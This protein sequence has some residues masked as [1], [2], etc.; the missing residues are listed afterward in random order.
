MNRALN[1]LSPQVLQTRLNF[2][3]GHKWFFKREFVISKVCGPTPNKYNFIVEQRNVF[4]QLVEA[5]PSLAK[6]FLWKKRCL[7]PLRAQGT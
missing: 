4:G 7:P 1:P 2:P 5:K 3:D 6:V